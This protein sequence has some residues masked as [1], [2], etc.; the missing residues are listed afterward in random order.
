MDR[1][2]SSEITVLLAAT[3]DHLPPSYTIPS[4]LLCYTNLLIYYLHESTC[5]AA[6]QLH[7]QHVLPNIS[8]IPPPTSNNRFHS[9]TFCQYQKL[10]PNLDVKASFSS[11][12]K[13]FRLLE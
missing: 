8:T 9:V 6:W 11:K 13:H 4:I 1:L 3:E 10:H 7:V 5:P 2:I 12:W